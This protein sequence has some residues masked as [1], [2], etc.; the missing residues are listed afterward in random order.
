MR[1]WWILCALLVIWPSEAFHIRSRAL[2]RS[3]DIVQNTILYGRVQNDQSAQLVSRKS[4]VDVDEKAESLD[5]ASGKNDGSFEVVAILTVY[6]VQGALGLA[7]LATSFYMKDTLHL[8]PA[9][10]AS[11]SGITT[12]PWV[13]KPIYGLLSDSFPIFGYRRRSYLV[14]AGG[15]GCLSWLA[16]GSGY[17]TSTPGVILAILLGSASVA[18]SDVVVDSIV[19]EKTREA[20]ES[21]QHQQEQ[22]QSQEGDN[23]G[24]AGDLQSLC[25]GAASVGGILSAYSSGS[26]LSVMSPQQVFTITALF[27]LLISASSFLI[28]EEKITTID[29]KDTLSL[30]SVEQEQ[31]VFAGIKTQL[32]EVWDTVQKPS[33]YL[34]VLFIFLWQGTPDPGAAMFYF[35]TNELGFQPEFLGQVRLASSIAALIGV[36][37]YRTY[38]K[39]RSIK[40]I[41]RWTTLA[42]LPLGL[43]QVLLTTHYNRVL[44]IP[45]QLFALADNVVLSVLGQ[46][47]FMPTLVLAARLCPIGSEGTLFA[48]LMSIY[49]FSGTLSSELG[50]LLTSAL[51]VGDGNYGNLTLLVVICTLSGGVP[52]LFTNLLDAAVNDEEG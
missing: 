45:D 43:S 48:T 37:V 25:W 3:N 31:A 6:F 51:G 33:I 17:M 11:L 13:I 24:T 10:M 2:V 4:K 52:L 5:D 30:R 21:Q 32:S 18:V 15:L 34:P 44:G 7:R 14:L 23:D 42:S 19:V 27:P 36:L 8:S 16:L 28:S 20:K 40:D 22:L 50:G 38:L 46:V 26:L 29:K 39:E 35:N 9:D 1:C 12:L 41:I 49:N 47:A